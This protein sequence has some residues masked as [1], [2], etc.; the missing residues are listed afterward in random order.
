MQ[1]VVVPS[2][3]ATLTSVV[4]RSHPIFCCTTPFTRNWV[5]PSCVTISSTEPAPSTAILRGRGRGGGY[6]EKQHLDNS[7]YL[8]FRLY[9]M[10]QG[11]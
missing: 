6:S 3:T 9:P 7:G 4:S 1:V 11:I 5:Q 10:M 2:L 8:R